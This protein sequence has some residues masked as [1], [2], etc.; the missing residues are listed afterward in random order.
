MAYS[1]LWPEENHSKYIHLQH[2]RN[3]ARWKFKSSVTE[4]RRASSPLNRE[5]Q[6]P[7]PRYIFGRASPILQLISI[8]TSLLFLHSLTFSPTLLLLHSYIIFAFIP[9]TTYLSST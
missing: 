2:H 3:Q 1:F 6:V 4:G 9:Y 8:F 7:R 5:N